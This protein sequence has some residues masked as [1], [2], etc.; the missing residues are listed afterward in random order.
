MKQFIFG[1]LILI[2]T[3]LIPQYTAAQA[4]FDKKIETLNHYTDFI[5]ETIHA[6]WVYK[7]NFD[8]FNY[9]L[10]AYVENRNVTLTYYDSDILYD[11]QAYSDLPEDIYTRCLDE[12]VNLPEQL[13]NNL[14]GSLHVIWRIML[15]IQNLNDSIALYVNNE[16]HKQDS[17]FQQPY[18]YLQRVERLFENYDTEKEQ[19]YRK[20]AEAARLY[21]RNDVSNQYQKTTVQ[22]NQMFASM[23]IIIAACRDNNAN[24]IQ[25]QLPVL[26]QTIQALNANKTTN[27]QG[28]RPFGS[29][30]GSDPFHVYESIM[31]DAEAFWQYASDFVNKDYFNTPYKEKGREYYYYNEK[32]LN[33]YNRYG[34]GAVRGFNQFIGL[35]DFPLL[36]RVEEP[37][38]FKVYIP[39]E[40]QPDSTEQQP[41]E[42]IADQNNQPVELTLQG[43]ADNNMIFLLDVS[44]SMS[45]PE[46]MPV[47]KEGVSFLLELMR[48]QDFISLITYSGNA[49]VVLRPTSAQNRDKIRDNINNLHS[50]GGTNTV[51]GLRLAFRTAKKHYIETGNNRIIMV[52]DGGFDLSPRLLRLSQRIAQN[53]MV[54]SIIYLNRYENEEAIE[55]L[56]NMALAGNGNFMQLTSE[57]I[58]IELLKEAQDFQ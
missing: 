28:L 52:T 15:S 50:A 58:K 41:P 10:N 13:K 29:S 1:F 39:E 48:P 37:H 43:Y 32:L 47:L 24:T 2:F 4:A 35:S 49:S 17:V 21:Q 30:N 54:L 44:S 16:Q 20:I 14:N 23:K 53:G 8:K 42:T 5:N 36:Q 27:L 51:R 9:S 6:L 18:E 3:A 7:A 19:L 26:Q 31:R 55:F 38:W 56:E 57:N 34:L 25:R 45:Q 40:Q 12:S 11:T 22:M 46:K 33:K